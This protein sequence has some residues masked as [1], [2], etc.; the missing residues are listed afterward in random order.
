MVSCSELKRKTNEK[1]RMDH[2]N[3]VEINGLEQIV[4]ERN[5][6]IAELQAEVNDVEKEAHNLTEE[7]KKNTAEAENEKGALLRT[8]EA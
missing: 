4:L 1:M 8:L 6:E 2:A 3:K 7:L 5:A